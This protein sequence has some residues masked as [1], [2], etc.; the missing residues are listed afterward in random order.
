MSNPLDHLDKLRIFV[1]VV[2]QEKISGSAALLGLTQPS[3]TRAIQKLEEAFETTLLIRGRYGVKL[4][5]SGEILYRSAS[6]MLHELSDVKTQMKES[7]DQFAGHLVVGSYESLAEYLWPDF[8]ASLRKTLPNLTVSVHTGNGRDVFRQLTDGKIDL[9]V[10]A[11]TRT[12]EL[13]TSW[14]LYT[15]RFG[16]Y[17]ASSE[18]GKTLTQADAKSETLLYV[19]NAQDQ[20]GIAIEHHIKLQNYSFK[21]E[22]IFDSFA[23]VKRLAIRG[24]G[25]AVL[26]MRLAEEDL[27]ARRLTPISLQGF[28]AHGFGKHTIYATCATQRARDPRIKKLV[29]LLK[30][31]FAH[32]V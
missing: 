13:T 20:A 4:T 7:H 30:A 15:D 22:G 28:G 32:S 18:R 10:D 19:P 12:S 21:Q 25:I 31:H 2:D 9:L 11:E 16:F 1:T 14:A 8:L 27:K 5:K 17:C 6:R 24:L 26:P 23:T 29:S 3:I